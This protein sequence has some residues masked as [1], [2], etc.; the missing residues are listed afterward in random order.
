MNKRNSFN[1]FLML[2]VLIPVLFFVTA[3]GSANCTGQG[4]V[5]RHL[6]RH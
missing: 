2:V 1:R 3:A 4:S 5:F 6:G